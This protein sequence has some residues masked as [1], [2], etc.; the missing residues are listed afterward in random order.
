[1]SLVK[2]IRKN[3]RKIMTFVVIFCMVA[4]IIGSFGLQMLSNIFGASNRVIA[5]YDNGKIKQKD[6][7]AASNELN[8]LK[9]L[10]ADRY[11]MA[12]GR[13][14]LAGPLT[15]KLIFPDSPFA[16][17]IAGQL[18][19]AVQQ[20]QLPLTNDE[21]D[22]YFNQPSERAE[23]LWILLRDEAYNAGC[24]TPTENARQTLK[25]IIP[26]MTGNQLDAAGLVSRIIGESNITEEQIIRV[27]A[28]LL[29]VIDYS[30]NV[31][32]NQAV[33]TNQV[34]ASLARGK[35][36]IDADFV[37]I[38]ADSFIDE[39]AEIADA[40]LQQQFDAYKNVLASAATDD[41]PFGFG[42][43]LP[44]R[45]KLEYIVV[46]MDDVKAQTAKITADEMESF[47]SRN[48]DQFTKE[49]P[50][51]AGQRKDPVTGQHVL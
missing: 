8:V 38:D 36:R 40:D 47:Y 23:I 31:M 32:N 35:E 30:A 45:V 22:D 10:M 48:L 18:K 16:G 20:G 42:Y 11:M 24:I 4:F 49:E 17:D 13:Q 41:N 19:Q 14:T 37:K 39:K 27:F 2:W 43:K 21:L 5:T 46:K 50:T 7:M 51:D 29:S 33:T 15:V 12:L 6:F 9:S 28:D 34:K 44:K 25:A 1:M 3:N 26:Q